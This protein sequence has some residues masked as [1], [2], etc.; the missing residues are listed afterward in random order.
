MVAS[1]VG[2]AILLFSCGPKKQTAEANLETMI[3]QQSD[4]LTMIYTKNGQKDYRFTTP[5]MERYEFARDPYMEFRYGIE[6]ITFDSLGNEASQLLADYAIYYEKRELWEARGNVRGRGEDG[7]RLYTQQIFW[8]E[9]TDKVYSNV[10]TKV[11]DGDDVFVG[12]GFESDS[13]FKDWVFRES[14]GRMWVD[15]S[16]G[17]STEGTAN[18]KEGKKEAPKE[19]AKVEQKAKNDTPK[20]AVKEQ[21]KPT[22][23]VQPKR[24]F[25][26]PDPANMKAPKDGKKGP[27]R[28]FGKPGGEGKELPALSK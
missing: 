10:D 28:R 26:R 5:L 9:K 12:E 7:R 22:Q 13:E 6:I 14:E 15:A 20:E 17:E 18:E 27:G 21:E 1:L 3:T 23:K 8:D 25:K 11:V 24:E 2:G 4:T 19:S 16:Q